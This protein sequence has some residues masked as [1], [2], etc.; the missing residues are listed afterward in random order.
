MMEVDA[1]GFSFLVFIRVVHGYTLIRQ[2]S[3][4]FRVSDRVT[5]RVRVRV[6]GCTIDACVLK[7]EG[8]VCA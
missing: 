8:N 7:T 4:R 3:V 5:I 2:R 1:C 6:R